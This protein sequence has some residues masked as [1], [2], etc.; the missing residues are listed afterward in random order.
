MRAKAKGRFIDPMLL[1]RTDSLP[2]DGDRWAYQLKFD[3]YRAIAFKTGGIALVLWLIVMVLIVHAIEAGL[4]VVNGLH[5]FLNDDPEL[6][7]CHV[8]Q[9]QTKDWNSTDPQNPKSKWWLSDGPFVGF[10]I[11]CEQ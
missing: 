5:Q 1:L 3:G 2:N 4:E 8:R 10:R 6:V 11:V 9:E 7:G